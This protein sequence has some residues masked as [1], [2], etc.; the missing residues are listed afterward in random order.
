VFEN[1]VIGTWSD[2]AANPDK[3]IANLLRQEEQPVRKFLELVTD[4]G[5]KIGVGKYNRQLRLKKL[6]RYCHE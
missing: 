6:R 1:G 2:F 4:D 3:F 5:K